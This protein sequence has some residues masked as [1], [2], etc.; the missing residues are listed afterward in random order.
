MKRVLLFFVIALFL[1]IASCMPQMSARIATHMAKTGL[2]ID[3]ETG[4]P[5]P[6]VI[7]IASGWSS[8]GGVVVGE[9]SYQKLYRIVSYTDADGRYLIPSTWHDMS[10]WLPG[11]D[12]RVGWAITVFH[13]GYAVVGDERAWEADK[14]GMMYV[15]AKSTNVIPPFSYKGSR[16]EVDSIKMYK[17][18]LT[19]KEA[20]TYYSK[21]KAM[22]SQDFASQ[23]PGDVA[24]RRQ[25]YA[26]FA[27]WVCALDPNTE[28]DRWTTNVTLGFAEDPINANVLRKALAPIDDHLDTYGAPPTKAG[29]V[30]EIMTN[31]R[32]VP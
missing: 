3:T 14:K 10:I 18:T 32:G 5:M 23:K 22:G 2:V 24:I 1:I 28:L 16:I 21:I 15:P 7:V 4:K 9:G 26:L 11:F 6:H 31:G 12:S 8:Q 29:V 17:P 20:A 25:G 30:C 27:P 19:L 13:T